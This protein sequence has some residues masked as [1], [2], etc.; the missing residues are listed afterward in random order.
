LKFTKTY[1]IKSTT[2]PG[3]VYIFVHFSEEWI[4]TNLPNSICF[5]NDWL[6]I[7][8]GI[9]TIKASNKHSY[10]WDGCTPKKILFDIVFGTPDGKLDVNTLKPITYY[11]SMFHDILYQ[12]LCQIPISRKEADQ[13]FYLLLKK[14]N[15]KLA[16]LYYLAVRIFGYFYRKSKYKNSKKVIIKSTSW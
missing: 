1:S 16:K 10:A 5:E 7:S 8:N 12:F 15:F 9:I 3:K 11:A 6:K 4:K 13:I 14:A 2:I